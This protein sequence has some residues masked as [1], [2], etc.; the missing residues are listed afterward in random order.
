MGNGEKKIVFWKRC[1]NQAFILSGVVDKNDK[2]F[3]IYLTRNQQKRVKLDKRGTEKAFA[4]T[5][6]ILDWLQGKV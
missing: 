6:P 2:D 3:T 1:T 4:D 5:K